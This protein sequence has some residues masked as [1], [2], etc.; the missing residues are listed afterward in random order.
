MNWH[1]RFITSSAFLLLVSAAIPVCGAQS[2]DRRQQARRIL[3]ST[4]LKGGL[5]VH[6]GCGDGKLTAALRAGASY[7]VHGLDSDPANIA[8]AREYIRSLAEYGSVAV[9]Q[10]S[11]NRLPYIDNSVNLIV[12]DDL[13]GVPES[14]LMR[15]LVPDGSAYVRSAGQWARTVKTRPSEIDEWTHYLHDPSNN[16][17]AHDSVIEPPSRYQ[18]IAGQR[19]SRQHDHMSSVSAVVSAN[20]RLFYIFDDAPRASILIPPRWRLIARDAF[21]GKHLWQRQI[22]LWHPHLWRLKSGPQML[23]RRLVASGDRVYVTLGIEA[24]LS[25]LDAA[26][27]KTI[28]TY[29]GT[30]A[31]EEVLLVDGVLI[32][33]VAGEGQPLRS[34]PRKRYSSLTEMNKDVTN[35]LWTQA[36]RTIMALD[37]DSGRVLWEKESDLVSLSLAAGGQRV[38]FH[39][40]ERIRC[41]D[42]RSGEPLWASESLPRKENMRSSGGATLVLYDDVV[43]YSGQVP[44]KPKQGTTSMF[45]LSVKDGKTLWKVPHHPCGHMGTPDDILVAGGL[46]WNGAVAKGNDSGIM[47][48]RDLHTGQIKSEFAPNVETHWFHHRC[49]R[50]KATD[51]YLLFSR[52]GIE[53]IDYAAENWI[54]HHWVRGACHYGIMPCNGLIYAP[55]HPCACYIE[56]KLYGFTALAP[57]SSTMQ[58]RRE[59]PDRE[60]LARGPAYGQIRETSDEKRATDDWPTFRHDTERSGAVKTTV[61]AT[62]LKR[63]WGTNLGG[64]LSTPVVADGRLFVASADTHSVHALDAVTG[65][66]LWSFTTGGRVDS[67]PTIWQGRAL[68]GSADGHVY[69]L[70]ANDGRLAWRYRAAPEDQ[71]M[72]AFEQIESVWPVHGS[73]LVL[74]EP[75]AASG[76]AVLYCVAGRSMFVDGGL[77]MLRLDPKTGRKLSETILDDKDP[78]TGENLQVHIDRLN[79]PVALPDILSSD[80]K[81]VYM[82]SLPFDLQGK[83]KFVTYVP[84]SE[85]Q[86]DDLHLFCPTGFL[87]DSLWHR[88]YWGYGR[89][90]ASGAGGYHQ[91]GRVI[92][93]GRPLVFDDET[94][95]GYGRL[96]QY[97]RWTTPLEFSLFAAKKQPEI[98]KAGT[99]RKAVKK[100][101]KRVG[102]R[103]APV[104][105]FA[106]DW[107]DDIS[108]Q[109]TSMVLTDGALFAAGPPDVADEEAAVKT[110][111]D[112]ETQK[113]LA[114]QSAA[115]EGKRGALLLAVSP[116]DGNKLAAYRLDFVPRFDGLIAANGR[117]YVST[118][119]GDVLCLSSV[120]GRPLAQAE[121]AVV[122]A[123]Q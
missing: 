123:R 52:T 83:R 31:T 43:L 48:G 7:V 37:A 41:L 19:Y 32:L 77:R 46:V 96:W 26:T 110:L 4:N 66:H 54:C 74:N 44:E 101:G 70:A 12:S 79:M 117:L 14:E 3:D 42:R 33:S 1:T 11:G 2:T 40:G 109:V 106:Q 89:A 60:R 45:A 116:D 85:Q 98:V 59:V 25:A 86:G 22:E 120:K 56:A 18:W 21:N 57:P 76:Q 9:E 35:P 84:V 30:K 71:R 64:K 15:V 105:R 72:I 69:C 65:E 122:A 20:G 95:Y 111:L 82:R 121:D 87:D 29:E 75:S 50:A 34:D 90:W 61:R 47:T 63:T 92:P 5:V 6:I 108:V 114:E 8:A 93:A 68:F 88:T 58:P 55:Q 17:V 97:Y 10:W 24:P 27:G 91:A 80:G 99:E 104:T 73:V 94:V 78:Q 81:Y 107:S 112:P 113:K 51:K 100:S 102:T 62:D 13:G 23:A 103:P 53:F 67:P 38:L 28:R 119:E 115:F 36:P 16:A 118:L 39:D 49:Y